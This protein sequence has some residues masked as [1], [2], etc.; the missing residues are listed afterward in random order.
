MYQ[1]ICKGFSE[2]THY[3]NFKLWLATYI[4]VANNA[5]TN[6]VNVAVLNFANSKLTFVNV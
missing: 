2:T 6:V 5:N 3:P 4:V 1:E